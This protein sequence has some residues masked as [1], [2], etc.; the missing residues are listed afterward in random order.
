[1][2]RNFHKRWWLTSPVHQGDH[3][4]AVKT[5]AQG[6]PCDSGG[7][8]EC[9]C[10][11]SFIAREAA[12]ASSIR[13]SLRPLLP[14]ARE[15]LAKL[16][17]VASR[18]R[19]GMSIP[20]IASGAKQ[21]RSRRVEGLDCFASRAMAKEWLFEIKTRLVGWAK[22]SV[23]TISTI[24]AAWWA[25]RKRAFAHP[26]NCVRGD[27]ERHYHTGSAMEYFTWL[28]AKL[29]SIEAMPSRRVSLFFRNAS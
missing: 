18:D 15:I 4:G 19:E 29:D 1:M 27:D 14:E 20:V 21:S 2:E 26:T 8:C 11:F 16:G 3:G 23:P 10:V 6:M 12:G 7:P 9:A 13:H 5:I 28:S 17:R 25:R 24:R 22:R